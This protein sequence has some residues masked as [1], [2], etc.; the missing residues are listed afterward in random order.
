MTWRAGLLGAAA[1]GTAMGGAM[2]PAWGAEPPVPA[3]AGAGAP[4]SPGP[5]A[6]APAGAGAGVGNAT[7]ALPQIDVRATPAA[8]DGYVPLRSRSATRTDTAVV[9]IPQ[10]LSVVSRQALRDTGAQ[11]LQDVARRVPGAGFAQGEGNRDTPVLRGQT[12]TAS[13]FRDGLRDDVQY[14]RDL[15]NVDR[16]EVLLGPNALAFGRGGA[17][18]VINRVTRQAEWDPVRELRAQA[19]SFGDYRGEADLGGGLTDTV[20]GRAMG[21]YQRSD[22]YRDGVKLR[23]YGIN[24][25]T[26]V[27]LGDATDLTVGYEYF[28][29]ERTADRGIPSYRGRPLETGTSTF[30]GDPNDSRSRASVNI[31]TAGLTHRFDNGMTWRTQMMVSDVAKFYQNIFP[32]AVNA[33]RTAVNITA[34]NNRTDRT[35]YFG[36]TDLSG[37]TRTGSVDHT[38]VVGGDLG[39]QDT[40]NLRN[41]GYFIGVGPNVTTFV[42]PLARS[43]IDV[44]VQFRHAAT[45]ASNVGTANSLAVFA[46]DQIRLHPL[47]ELVLG[48]RYEYFDL[49]F[50][51]RNLNQRLRIHNNT[52]SPRL[53]L[54]IHPLP[55]VTLYASHITSYLPRAGE[56]LAS[57]TLANRA[58]QPESLTNTEVGAKWQATE[59]LLLTASAYILDRTNVAITDPA[60]VT[61]SILAR[62]TTTQGFELSAAGR[63]TERWQVIAGYANT[64]GRFT[65]AQ[66]A[67]IRKDNSVP[68]VARNTLSLW[69]RVDVLERLGLGVGV[70]HQ[71]AYYAA[72]DN[73]VRIPGFTRLDAA[74]F[75]K[76]T[77]RVDLQA[78]FENLNGATYYPVA[79]NNNNITPGAPFSMR[80][81]VT[82]RF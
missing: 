60:N 11:N 59:N 21:V 66:S 32:G 10:S 49:D 25:T 29:D 40:D 23:R 68:F 67:T 56:Q 33:A 47:V 2:A 43:R 5:A 6:P 38:W 48:L 8:T 9:D 31:A 18:G 46:Q 45:D 7:I 16:V 4:A 41:T 70:I 26:T 1:M 51:N 76:L 14:Y 20:A 34:Y 72:A 75:V 57:L 55:E 12:T 42:T 30:F 52:L 24:P 54:L 15:Y 35:G 77:E 71:S 79:D 63:V 82:A 39:R 74:V 3:A 36:Q 27:R 62:G 80:W 65:Q 81:A 58:L 53:G 19:G 22:L 61:R 44:P 28:R 13:L 73:T 69:N 50:L 17:G 78:N 64:N 37:T